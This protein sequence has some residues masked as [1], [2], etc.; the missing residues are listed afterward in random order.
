[1]SAPVAD[2]DTPTAG[3]AMCHYRR[4]GCEWAVVYRTFA[5]E[6]EA[7]EMRRRHELV[8]EHAPRSA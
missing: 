7:M 4:F 8:C 2:P 5:D 3:W 6:P 1:M